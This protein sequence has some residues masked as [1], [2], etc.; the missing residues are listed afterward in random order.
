MRAMHCGNIIIVIPKGGIQCKLNMGMH[1]VLRGLKMYSFLKFT[2][3]IFTKPTAQSDNLKSQSIIQF[4][5]N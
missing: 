4:D 2:K 3:K 5:L 1:K